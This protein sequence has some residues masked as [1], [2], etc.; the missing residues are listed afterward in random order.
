MDDA[1]L[2]NETKIGVNHKLEL[3][4]NALESKILD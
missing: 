4:R 1:V 3:W 2:V